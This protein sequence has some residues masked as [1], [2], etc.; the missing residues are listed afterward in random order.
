MPLDPV[1][2][3]R[4]VLSPD[5][6]PPFI[7]D[8]PN[9]DLVR[10][11]LDVADDER[12]EAAEEQFVDELSKE[13]VEETLDEDVDQDGSPGDGYPSSPELSAIHQEDILIE[14]AEKD[15]DFVDDSEEDEP[16]RDFDDDDEA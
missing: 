1:E 4:D 12:R 11:G 3:A 14:N 7:D 5:N 15:S 10:E 13:E 16:D 8:Y 2:S 6:D 9:V